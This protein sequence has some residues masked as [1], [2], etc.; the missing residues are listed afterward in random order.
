MGM[1]F[2]HFSL[3]PH[4][5]VPGNVAFPLEIQSVGREIRKRR[6]RPAPA[7]DTGAGQGQHHPT[8]PRRR[9]TSSP[10]SFNPVTRTCSIGG[11]GS[12]GPRFTLR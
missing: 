6:D 7:Q 5:T 9:P 8:V 2:R 10:C 11:P 12:P 3:L 1:V 4:L